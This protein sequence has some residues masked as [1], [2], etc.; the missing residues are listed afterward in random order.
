[1]ESTLADFRF[2]SAAELALLAE[3]CLCRDR[4]QQIR[5][6]IQQ[7]GICVEGSRGQPRPNPLLGAENDC[8]RSLIALARALQITDAEDL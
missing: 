2:T 3:Y 5:E 4:L 7:A 6:A 1:V 8:R